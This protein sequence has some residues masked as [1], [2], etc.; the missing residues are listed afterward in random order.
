MEMAKSRG[1]LTMTTGVNRMTKAI[2][3]MELPSSEGGVVPEFV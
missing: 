2:S 1:E 3:R